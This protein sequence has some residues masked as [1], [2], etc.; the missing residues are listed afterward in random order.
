MDEETD[1][2]ASNLATKDRSKSSSTSAHSDVAQPSFEDLATVGHEI[3]RTHYPTSAK[4][5]LSQLRA[6]CEKQKYEKEDP[7]SKDDDHDKN[8]K[9]HA[10]TP[11][12][13]T[14]KDKLES[15]DTPTAT[16]NH[17]QADGLQYRL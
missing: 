5:Y 13:S 6:K 2:A 11:D 3:N 14:K 16:H 15:N 1:I 17:H 12:I 8:D 9:K 4:P 7:G 10:N